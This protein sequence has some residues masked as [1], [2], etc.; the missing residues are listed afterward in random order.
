[1]HIINIKLKCSIC[2]K[3]HHIH[4]NNIRKKDINNIKCNKCNFA[5]HIYTIKLYD[6]SGLTYQ[7]NLEYDFIKKC[8]EKN[9]YIINGIEI[10]YI[11][12]GKNHTYI[13]DFYL[14]E[15]KKII[16]LK[17][18]NLFYKKDL[19]SGRIAAKNNA[20]IQF[21]TENNL[22]FVMIMD[23]DIDEFLNTL[24]KEIV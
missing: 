13:S 2:G 20:A 22:S 1:M 23:S 8:K 15:Y 3:I 24:H 10:P 11:L 18:N 16:E 19:A 17:A 21:A 12:N 7:S 4:T 6:D 9:I 5:N 14:P